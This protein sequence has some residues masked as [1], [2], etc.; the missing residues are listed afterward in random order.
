MSETVKGLFHDAWSLRYFRSMS[1]AS[2]MDMV[3]KCGSFEMAGLGLL[4]AHQTLEC[5]LKLFRN[6]IKGDDRDWA[7][8]VVKSMGVTDRIGLALHCLSKFYPD[9]DDYKDMKWFV[10]ALL[11]DSKE[12]MDTLEAILGDNRVLERIGQKERELALSNLFWF[13]TI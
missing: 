9:S 2:L 13:K 5:Q 4:L 10:T 3:R 8:T 12:N 7:R 6:L 11:D 1:N